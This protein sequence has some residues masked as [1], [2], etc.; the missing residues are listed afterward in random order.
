MTSSHLPGDSGPLELFEHDGEVRLSIANVEHMPPFLMSVLSSTDLWMFVASNGGLTA[1]RMSAEHS[2]F[3]YETVD[4]L[5]ERPGLGGPITLI[6]IDDRV[7]A[8]FDPRAD[9][10]EI[11]RTVSKSDLGDRV[12]FE[13]RHTGYGLGFRYEW[14]PSEDFG[15]VRTAELWTTGSSPRTVEVL[16]GL[17]DVLPAG[18]ALSTQQRAS[19][20]IDAYRHSELYEEPCHL[21]LY[22]LSSLLTDRAEPAEALRANAV[23]RTGLPGP[24]HLSPEVINRWR[25]RQPIEPTNHLRGKKGAYLVTTTIT[26]NVDDP[27]RWSLV[28]D[29]SLD[30]VKMAALR[31]ELNRDDV[32]GRLDRS[33]ETTRTGLKQLVAAIDGQQRTGD[34]IINL[35][36]LSN[37]LFNGLRGG[38]L[39]NEGRV[40]RAELED[41]VRLRNR[42]VADHHRAWM[43][44]QPELVDIE[45]LRRSAS[46][47]GDSDLLR[48]VDEMLPLAFGRRHGDPS[49][50]WNRFSIRTK[51]DSGERA[52][53]YEGNWR[54]IFQNWE[55]LA[56]GFP[57][58]LPSMIAKFVNASTVDGFNPYR[59]SREGIDWEVPDPEDPWSNIGYWGD[60]QIIYL[61][62]L[63]E[64]LHAYRPAMLEEML[65][66]RRF[67][68]GDVPYRI[69]P[70]A[71]MLKTPRDTIEFDEE[72]HA[73]IEERVGDVGQDGR[74]VWRGS[75]V[76]LTHL[77]E[78][79]LIP[80]LSKLSNLVV[81]GGIWMNT[82]RPEWNDANNA[83]PGYGLSVV[84]LAHTLRYAR[85]LAQLIRGRT[86]PLELTTCVRGWLEGVGQVLASVA[87]KTSP[88]S[89]EERRLTM[90]RLGQVFS[91]YRS[92]VYQGWPTATLPVPAEA[93]AGFL[94]DASRV[95]EQSF[96]ANLRDDGLFHSYN[97]M[98]IEP[99][100]VHIHRLSLMLEGQVAALD[101]QVLSPAEAAALVDAMFD[102][103]L[104]RSDQN[105]F[106]LYPDKI[107]PDFEARNR[108]PEDDA[109]AIDAVQRWLHAGDARIIGVDRS[110][111]LHFHS[112]LKN[113]EVLRD[114][115]DALEREVDG[116]PFTDPDR[117][118]LLALYE[119]TFRHA[120]F[121]G[122]S[123]SMYGFEGLG[124]VYWHMVAKLLVAVQESHRRATREGMDAAPLVEAYDRVRAGLS[125]NKSP[126]VYGAFPTDAYSHTPGHSGAQQPGMTGQ[127]K[128]QVLT[129]FGELGLRTDGGCL[130]FEPALLKNGELLPAD[131]T[132]QLTATDGRAR[133]EHLPKGGLGFTLAGVVVVYRTDG[134]PDTLRITGHD[135]QTRDVQ[136]RRL[137]P[138]TTRAL[139]GR[140]QIARIDVWFSANRFRP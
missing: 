44:Q 125:F 114:R 37:A 63:L 21:A 67:S 69:C 83:L 106:L 19:N 124:C 97:T 74:L 100:A 91:E 65:D 89:A 53:H 1:G 31:S 84:T 47:R 51:T 57:E 38:V 41:F 95:L 88:V 39:I 129:R 59:I 128:E 34:R 81:D 126:A 10:P 119:R 5:Y 60:H 99:H 94:A 14:M 87:A 6:R 73:R 50:P 48:L 137:D 32:A 3:P 102:S 40:P 43:A 46:T 22:S 131:V 103:A 2:L 109:K 71:Q 82:Q 49:R 133:Q 118:R 72:H 36:H 58:Y 108:V 68:F 105:T 25:R 78:K 76:A 61:L 136:G 11:V 26:P 135:G 55:A 132:W 9:D 77:W 104:Y 66:Q 130:S 93:V 79:L 35:N 30:S 20:L 101:A 45:S 56:V 139:F 140:N 7:W 85:F 112:D 116:T 62:R 111:G 110:G 28:G 86:T 4:R 15:W 80:L 64:T 134:E 16:D 24:T 29:V 12:A 138:S 113:E 122:R 123:A 107:L 127:V 52:I 17:L 117:E 96:R 18:V 8:P 27:V 33:I 120:E 70:Y 98:S 42:R 23:W 121:T 13:E 54:D 75:D 115:L 92:S 90:D